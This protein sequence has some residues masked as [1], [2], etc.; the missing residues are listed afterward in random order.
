MVV[1][2]FCGS[3][4]AVVPLCTIVLEPTGTGSWKV[5]T[6]EPVAKLRNLSAAG[7]LTHCSL[8]KTVLSSVWV[9]LAIGNVLLSTDWQLATNT[10][11]NHILV[12]IRTLDPWPL[13]TKRSSCRRIEIL[14][15]GPCWF[16][17]SAPEPGTFRRLFSSFEAFFNTILRHAHPDF[18]PLFQIED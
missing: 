16:T 9:Q 8:F 15:P 6:S 2:G 1:G 7:P 4:P 5:E 18:Y 17:S 14:L 3:E 13:T 12:Q 10:A 11:S